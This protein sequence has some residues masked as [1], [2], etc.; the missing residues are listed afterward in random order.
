VLACTPFDFVLS[1]TAP[2]ARYPAE[3]ACPGN[4]PHRAL[5]H[6]AF[7]VAWN[8]SEQ[9]AAA[10]NWRFDDQG[11]PLGVQLIGRRFDDMG[12]LRMARLIEQLRPAQ[13]GWP[14]R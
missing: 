4:D 8:M 3:H 14:V 7:T 13:R 9:P 11:L 5:D 1:P 6:I 10:I 12:V 2:I